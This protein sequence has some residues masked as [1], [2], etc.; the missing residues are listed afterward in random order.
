M[1]IALAAVVL[2]A[3]M[4]FTVLRPK[5]DTSA[6]APIAAQ[7]APKSTPSAPGT[8]GLASAV[9][10]AKGAV[11]TSEASA[12]ATESAATQAGGDTPTTASPSSAPAA[13]AA[14]PKATATTKAAPAPTPVKVEDA[15]PST[16]LFPFLAKGKTVVLLFYGKGAEDQAA[17]KA[18]RR[19]AQADKNVISAYAP[20]TDVGKYEAITTDV[21]VLTAPTVLVIGEDHKARA[22][23][24][25]LDAA[26]I[27]Q[28]VGDVRRALKAVPAAATPAG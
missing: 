16:R 2:L 26:T 7:P 22:L 24:G 28:A 27:K 19:T 1:Q 9:D 3:G 8:A 20:I 21:T 10:K 25:F 11:A 14:A 15:D 5:G 12:K 17:R 18:V 13:T 23:D 4:W 6:D